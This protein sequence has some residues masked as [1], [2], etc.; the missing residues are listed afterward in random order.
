MLWDVIIKNN[1]IV[2][3]RQVFVFLFFFFFFL[4]EDSC[5]RGQYLSYI[6]Y[7]A[8]SSA[9]SFICHTSIIHNRSRCLNSSQGEKPWRISKKTSRKH[10][11]NIKNSITPP[12]PMVCLLINMKSILRHYDP[13]PIIFP[14]TGPKSSTLNSI[15]VFFASLVYIY[16]STF[17]ISFR[18]SHS[19]WFLTFPSINL[20]PTK[21]TTTNLHPL[22]THTMT[23]K[24]FM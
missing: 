12:S 15:F 16:K 24:I 8:S 19:I 14:L 10:R 3:L 21:H 13:I 22:Q 18:F 6:W 7:E 11:E 9:T 17:Q 4:Q 23:P 20:S 1:S 5:K 2:L